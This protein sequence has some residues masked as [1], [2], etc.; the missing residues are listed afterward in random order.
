[1][2]NAYNRTDDE[3]NITHDA[4]RQRRYNATHQYQQ[5]QRGG[6]RFLRKHGKPDL[7][8]LHNRAEQSQHVVEQTGMSR[9]IAR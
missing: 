5:L 7:K 2:R 4:K 9:R 3:E 6:F 8:K 1:M